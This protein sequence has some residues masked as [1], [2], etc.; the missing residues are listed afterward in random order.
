MKH[1]VKFVFFLVALLSGPTLLAQNVSTGVDNSGN[2]VGNGN[3]DPNWVITS[4]PVTGASRQVA[5]VPGAWNPTPVAGTNAGWINHNGTF[6]TTPGVYTLERSFVVAAG[7]C[8]FS[9]NFS[10]AYDDIL[11]SIE[12]VP[13][14]GSP[15]PLGIPPRLNYNLGAPIV[16]TIPSPTPGVW[17]IRVVNNHVDS[18]GAFLL[19]GSIS[20]NGAVCR[21]LTAEF[22]YC[23]NKC[24]ISLFGSVQG[25]ACLQNLTY[26]W[27]VNGTLVGS[28]Q[29]YTHTFSANGTYAVC[30]KVSSVTADGTTCQKEVCREVVVKDCDSCNCDELKIN[31][32][33]SRERCTLVLSG[34]AQAPKCLQNLTYNWYVNG[35]LVGSGQNHNHTFSANGTYA[36]CLKVSGV[37]ANG[38]ICQK[39]VCREVVVKD[40]ERC[41]CDELRINFD[42]SLDRCRLSLAGSAQG[43][44]CFQRLTYDWYVNGTL[45]GSG[46]NYVH[47]FSANGTYAVCLRVSGV[48][49]DGTVCRKEICREVVVRDCERCNCEALNIDF[50]QSL[51][52]CKLSLF[53]AAQGPAC[54]GNLT[55]NWYVNGILVGSGQNYVHTFTSNG[56]Y[57]VCLQVSSGSIKDGTL[58]RKEICREV[59]VRDCGEGCNCDDLRINFEQSLERC[60]LSLVGLAEGPKCFQRLIYDWYVNGNL[61]GS[62]PG[63]VH[64][65]SS[66]GTYAVCLKVSAVTSDGTVCRKEICREVVVKDC[67]RCDCRSLNINFDYS[68]DRRCN[69]LLVGSAQGAACLQNLTYDWYVNGLSV[70][71][72]QNYIVPFQGGTRDVICLIVSSVMPDGTICQKEICRTIRFGCLVFP[73]NL[74]PGGPYPYEPRPIGIELQKKE[75][76]LFPNPA[77]T[78]INV[79]FDLDAA[80]DVS[81]ALKTMDGKVV[82][83]QN[84]RA[85]AGAQR[86]KIS[87]PSHVAEG[88]LLVEITAGEATIRR[89]V[90]VSK[91]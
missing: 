55:Y 19:S 82:T 34:S 91:Q 57:A 50:E 37:T 42:Q 68:F 2:S 70:G 61:V 6:T 54:L 90:S 44:A 56:T 3:V 81:I 67:E 48:T 78:E 36:V 21:D 31:F 1:F 80:T 74:E 87:I 11:V 85:E 4:G 41:N 72:G 7:T 65:F 13:S 49:A 71:S 60:K 22:E 14:V 40:C 45:V 12:L 64:T 73:E 10:V 20:H 9:T 5:S 28:G 51:E 32:E 46:Q 23:L 26:D 52:G 25:A 27:Y 17:K 35:N 88:M 16:V 84:R 30:L 79:A 89:K 76:Q 38:A 24:K 58:C 59:V 63:Y 83:R 47:T 29:N 39:E 18:I 69:L 75:I 62:G 53:G 66:N 77:N 86:F 8:S 43:P 15:I 33:Q